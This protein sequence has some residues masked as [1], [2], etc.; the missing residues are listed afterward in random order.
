MVPLYR[1]WKGLKDIGQK[2]LD[3]TV[4]VALG[5]KIKSVEQT[6]FLLVQLQYNHI[7]KTDNDPGILAE[8]DDN[9]DNLPRCL[10]QE[11]EEKALGNIL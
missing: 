2:K 6:L 7:W 3:K 1:L 10:K 5:E 9:N 8:W 4:L 11:D